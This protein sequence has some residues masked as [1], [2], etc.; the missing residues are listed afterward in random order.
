MIINIVLLCV[1]F[2]IDYYTGVKNRKSEMKNILEYKV[3]RYLMLHVAGVPDRWSALQST[4]LE[5]NGW[6][7]RTGD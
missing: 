1:Y 6:R 4:I 3:V 5:R 7:R 2:L